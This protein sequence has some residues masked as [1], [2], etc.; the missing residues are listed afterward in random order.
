MNRIYNIWILIVTVLTFPF[1]IAIGNNLD[2]SFFGL[3]I[4]GEEFKYKELV[5]TISAGLIFLLGVLRSSKKWLGMRVVK[6]V[7]RFKFSTPISDKRKN[8]VLLYNIIEILFYVI[9]AGGLLYFST[10]A[11]YVILVFA[12]LALDSI[13]N[14]FLGIKGK[15]YRVG[16]TKNAIVMADRETKA[17]YFKGLKKISKH[18]QTLYFE[19]VNGLVLHFPNDLLPEDQWTNFVSTLQQQVSPENVYYT[20]F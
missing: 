13:I 15:K 6:Q 10:S 19:Y 14:T 20:G 8:R 2:F 17:I 9:F 7:H 1:A 11:I 18:Q 12:I 16:L 4:P 3:S 5:F